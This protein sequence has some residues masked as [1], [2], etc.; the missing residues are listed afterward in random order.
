MAELQKFVL[1]SQVISLYRKFIRA[2]RSLPAGNKEDVL[3]EV[4]REFELQREKA[5]PYDIKYALSDGRT[6]LRMLEEAI[7]FSR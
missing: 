1:R 3:S 4:R 2:A 6:R 5:A 7:G